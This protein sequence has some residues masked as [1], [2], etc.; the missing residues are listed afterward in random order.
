MLTVATACDGEVE[1]FGG[2]D[3]NWV[4]DWKAYIVYGVVAVLM[5]AIYLILLVMKYYETTD[6]IFQDFGLRIIFQLMKIPDLEDFMKHHDDE[7]FK[8]DNNMILLRNKLFANKDSKREQCVKFYD[9]EMAFH[10]G[11]VAAA[12]CC[13]KNSLHLYVFNFVNGEKYPG[14][15]SDHYLAEKIRKS[16]EQL[17]WVLWTIKKVKLIVSAYFDILTD[18]SVLLILLGTVG[19][20]S[21]W[22]YPAK[23]TSVVIFC[24]IATLISCLF[25]S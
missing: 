12:R 22:N 21:L 25:A 11:D 7:E 15:L 10:A 5:A 3:E 6:I 14:Y 16:L 18:I 2:L 23:L 20:K 9:N 19:L 1:C 13:M 17:N 24:M 8:A 4:C